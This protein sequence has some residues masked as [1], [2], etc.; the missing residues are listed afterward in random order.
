MRAPREGSSQPPTLPPDART[1]FHAAVPSRL[2]EQYD[3]GMDVDLNTDELEPDDVWVRPPS[4]LNR[5]VAPS[6]LPP[7]G[8][9]LRRP[10]SAR[11]RR[12]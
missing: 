6:S 11:G 9:R 3:D 8:T 4:H 5:D 2:Q 1:G 10:C 12:S 7:Q